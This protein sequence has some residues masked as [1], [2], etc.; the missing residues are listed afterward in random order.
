MVEDEAEEWMEAVNAAH[1]SIPN[2]TRYNTGVLL[3]VLS[4]PVDLSVVYSTS[5]DKGDDEE[6]DSGLV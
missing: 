1:S 4:K 3:M 2:G 6:L 5:D